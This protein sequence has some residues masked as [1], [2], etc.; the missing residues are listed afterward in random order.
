MWYETRELDQ[1]ELT[2]YI[3]KEK[4]RCGKKNCRCF[5]EG[6]KHEAFYLYYR[7]SELIIDSLI[8]Y[9]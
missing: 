6:V 1:P 5:R 3:V 7:D 9:S 4:V 2:G 8:C